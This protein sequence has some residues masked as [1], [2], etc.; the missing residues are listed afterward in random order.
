MLR[1]SLSKNSFQVE[2]EKMAIKEKYAATVQTADEE[3][4]NSSGVGDNKKKN[5]GRNSRER[6]N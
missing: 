1:E 5:S 2:L 6:Q 3:E 4:S